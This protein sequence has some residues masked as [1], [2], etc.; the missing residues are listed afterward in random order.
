MGEMERGGIEGN[1]W[2]VKNGGNED[3]R[4]MYRLEFREKME[5]IEKRE[6]L[7]DEKGEWEGIMNVNKKR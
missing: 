5:G 3:K 7:E 4:E 1:L 6:G 2:G